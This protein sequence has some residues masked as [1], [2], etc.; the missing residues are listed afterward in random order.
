MVRAVPAGHLCRRAGHLAAN[1]VAALLHLLLLLLRAAA[2]LWA[3]ARPALLR[4]ARWAAAGALDVEGKR[5][6]WQ[7]CQ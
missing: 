7:G 2:E 1:A 4:T 5:S 6:M 3:A